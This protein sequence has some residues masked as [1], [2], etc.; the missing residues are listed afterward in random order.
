[1]IKLDGYQEYAK[2][3]LLKRMYVN[4]CTGGGLFADPGLG[5]TVITLS[6]IQSLRAMRVIRKTLIVAPIDVIY[7][8]WPEE[9]NKFN[10]P[11][12]TSLI[13]GNRKQRMAALR[14]PADIHLINPQGIR[15][16]TEVCHGGWD[17][18][19]VD[20][21]TCFKNWAAKQTQA[22]IKTL[23]WFAKVI[24]LTGTPQPNSVKDLFSQV[25]LLDRGETLG[26]SQNVFHK[27][28]CE[29][30]GF[31]GHEWK[32][33][34]GSES[35]IRKAVAPLCLRLDEAD[36]LDLPDRVESAQWV[37]MPAKAR[38]EYDRMERELFVLLDRGEELTAT[39][40]GAK[41]ALCRSI[42]NGAIY[43][44]EEWQNSRGTIAQRVKETHHLHDAKVERLERLHESIYRKPLI[45][46]Y[47][48]K[49]DLERI[50]KT[51]PKAPVI[52]GGQRTKSAMKKRLTI[53]NEWNLG[54]IPLLLI[55]PQSLSHGANLQ[56]GGNHL[57]WFGLPLSLEIYQQFNKRIHRRG[58]TKTCHF[59]HIL[60]L[61]TVEVAGWEALKAKASNQTQLLNFLKAYHREKINV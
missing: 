40:A 48:F 53:L 24:I 33:L 35:E 44:K 14:T 3:W 39:S 46:A 20:E 25:Y 26:R 21:S 6:L 56:F 4:E 36:H 34:A 1:M 42:A 37:E 30:G 47:Q 50:K 17:L 5:K 60:C 11:F 51:F 23:D 61:D 49:H 15:W 55:Q 59:H 22:L 43:E 7:K 52:G 8:T 58:V 28:Y 54:K 38:K 10:L 2:E 45:V 31:Q 19:V 18:L 16:L 27:R 29:K 32:P 13:H 9:V 57:A 41:Y 12:K